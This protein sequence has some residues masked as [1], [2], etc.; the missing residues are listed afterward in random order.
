MPTVYS[1]SI[2]FHVQETLQRGSKL[3]L[4]SRDHLA[5]MDVCCW[6]GRSWIQINLYH[7]MSLESPT[8]RFYS[9]KANVL[10]WI[11]FYI[12]LFNSWTLVRV[13]NLVMGKLFKSV[14]TNITK[15]TRKISSDRLCHLLSRDCR[16]IFRTLPA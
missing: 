14:L 2:K 15:H 11:I 16:R 7:I 13:S 1:V 8:G 12:S 6:L 9:K 10:K 3:I 5:I 4:K